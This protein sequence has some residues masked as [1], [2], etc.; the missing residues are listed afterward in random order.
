MTE[1]FIYFNTILYNFFSFL[2]EYLVNLLFII[3]V[4]FFQSTVSPSH[5]N[6]ATL[7]YS[8]VPNPSLSQGSQWCHTEQPCQWTLCQFHVIDTEF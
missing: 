8:V 2:T 5:N 1:Y 6:S 4:S 7:Y 3:L